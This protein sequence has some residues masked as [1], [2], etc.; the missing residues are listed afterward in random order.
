MEKTPAP[1][2]RP[3]ADS[4]TPHDDPYGLG[5]AIG[6]RHAQPASFA[7][8]VTPRGPEPLDARSYEL[9]WKQG[10]EDFR[11]EL[12]VTLPTDAPSA[13]VAAHAALLRWRGLATAARE[14]SDVFSAHDVKGSAL[15]VRCAKALAEGGMSMTAADKAASEHPDYVLHKETATLLG[16]AR[17]AAQ[18]AAQQAF[19]TLQNAREYMRVLAPLGLTVAS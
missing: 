17:A 3:L 12:A 11:N 4:S 7:A 16:A 19:E 14:A 18:D 15:R 10:R 9:G 13:M 8:D 2:P 6:S 5:D 1:R